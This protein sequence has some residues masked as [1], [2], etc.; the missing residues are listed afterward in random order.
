MKQIILLTGLLLFAHAIAGA[1][2]PPRSEAAEQSRPAASPTPIPPGVPARPGLAFELSEYG[3]TFQTEPRLII[4]MA[5]LEAAGFDAVPAGAEPSAFR[6]QVRKDLASLDPDLRNRLRTF[7][8]RN[9]LPAPATAA[10][11]AARYV[12]LAFV[13]APPPTLEAPARSEDLPSSL[14]EVLDFAPLVKEFYRRA[15]IEENLPAY[16]RAY[17]AESD[18]LRKPASDMVRDVLSYLHT[19]PLLVT[20]ERVPVKPATTPKKNAP[21]S[22]RTIEHARHFYIVTDL[23]AAPGTINFRVIGD[24]YY[25]VVPQGTDP[26]SSEL[27]RGYLQYVIDPLVLRFNREIA[28]QRE[29]IKLIIAEREKSGAALSPDVFLAVSRSLVA[30]SDARYEEKRRLDNLQQEARARLATAKDNTAKQAIAKE[31][32][33]GTKE[34]ADETVARLA[35]D[36]ERGAIL[37]FFFADQL[38]GIESSGFDVTSFLADMIASIDPAREA[39]RLTE[40][41]EARQRALTAR[42]LRVTARRAEADPPVYSEA[43]AARAA[44]L[45]KKLGEIEQ[46]LRAKDYNNAEARLKDLLK[47]YSR[48]PRIFF[49]LAQTASLAA[50]DA[51]DEDVQAERLKRALGNYR[52]AV[53]ASSPETDRALISRAYEAMG[54]IHSFLDNSGEAAKEFDEAIRIGDVPGGAFKDAVEGRKKLPPK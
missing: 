22:Y 48:E 18:R 33:T 19:R 1:Q 9:K 35:D 20:L 54:R 28:A 40:N 45:V 13:L 51:I 47:D 2:T 37:D 24:E 52:L 17:Q 5:A 11:Q 46:T 43:D 39:H 36:Y 44:F 25:V 42:Q 26:A 21:R 23:L 30:A 7:F 8:D 10:D 6:A 50:A 49:A 3:V 38:K 27:R 32:A 41:A 16:T 4:M 12:S 29:Q 15:N 14:L 53:E 31:L 34:L